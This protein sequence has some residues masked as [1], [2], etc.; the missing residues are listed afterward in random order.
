V[1]ITRRAVPFEDPLSL[2]PRAI[3]KLYNLWVCATYPFASNASGLWLDYTCEIDRTTAHRIGLGAIVRLRR[4]S[5]LQIVAA[6][7]EEAGLKI[8]IDGPYG[9]GA[10]ATICAKNRVH[11][12]RNVAM[13]SSVLIMDHMPRYQDVSKPIKNQGVAEGGT[14]RIG[15][16]TWIGQGTAILCSKGEL[17]LGRHC[18]V[19]ANSV[20]TRSFPPYSLIAGNPARVIQHFD[21]ANAEWVLGDSSSARRAPGK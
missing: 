19:A 12:E 21:A 20:I 6:P 1:N 15:E 14:I 2:L 16:G 4:D 17:V 11:L 18:I 5:R 10:R 9:V 3:R 7:N 8:V 13:G